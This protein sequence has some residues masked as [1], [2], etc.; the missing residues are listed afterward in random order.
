MIY[1]ISDV[2]NVPIILLLLFFVSEFILFSFKIIFCLQITA[3]FII[4]VCC[5][6]INELKEIE[7]T[8]IKTGVSNWWNDIRKEFSTKPV[9][10]TFISTC[11]WGFIAHGIALTNKFCWQ[12]EMNYVFTLGN[13]YTLGRFMLGFFLKSDNVIWGSNPFS[14]PLFNGLFSLLFLAIISV[15]IIKIFDIENIFLGIVLSGILTTIPVVAVIFA[16]MYTAPA[17]FFGFLLGVLGIYLINKYNNII[18]YIISIILMALSVGT[19]QGFLP[20]LLGIMLIMFLNFIWKNKENLKEKNN[21]KKGCSIVFSVPLFVLIYYVLM[22]LINKALQ[23]TLSDYRGVSSMGRLGIKEYLSRSVTAY[24]RFFFPADNRADNVF[25]Y[26]SKYL[27]YFVI[28]INIA[29]LIILAVRN[30]KKNRAGTILFIV[31][32]AFIPLA[33]NFIYVMCNEGDVYT[34]M[35]YG[36]TV[37]LLYSIFLTQ[38]I[39]KEFEKKK[40]VLINAAI[41]TILCLFFAKID[42]ICYLKTQFVQQQ[43]ISYFTA[44]ISDIKGTYG[45]SDE[46]PVATINNFNIN[47][48]SF[49]EIPEFTLPLVPYDHNVND[50]VNNYQY[51]NFMAYWCGYEPEYVPNTTEIEQNP[52]VQNMPSYPK[53]GSI[54]VI[55]GTVVVKF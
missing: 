24:K 3:K 33:G 36:L 54:K 2:L 5:K 16:Y 47:D 18:V 12:D 34:I 29:L 17:Y 22:K 46:Y 1:G 55:D 43:A 4:I 11:I 38:L 48:A 13:D 15:L 14:T 35:A 32:S 23:I 39:L 21:I 10:I 31:F 8:K 20:T 27:Y 30:F 49:T 44:L 53:D 42:N 41:L 50:Y 9:I 6:K 37:P 7:M 26:N 40:F 19:Y 52:E 45:Y 51:R 28:L 25:L